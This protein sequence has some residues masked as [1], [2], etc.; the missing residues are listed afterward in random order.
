MPVYGDHQTASYSRPGSSYHK[1][2]MGCNESCDW[3]SISS[4]VSSTL[5]PAPNKVDK[6]REILNSNGRNFSSEAVKRLA[7][8]EIYYG[9]LFI[10][11]TER[12]ER[13]TVNELIS[14]IGGA[15]GA[16]AGISLITIYQAFIYLAM[17]CTNMLAARRARQQA[18]LARAG[19]KV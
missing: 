17:G 3:Q 1:C 15:L 14:N 19:L 5:F 2:K 16:W 6:L 8:V 11:Y 13:A 9:S 18:L 7:L 10:R 4:V 12:M